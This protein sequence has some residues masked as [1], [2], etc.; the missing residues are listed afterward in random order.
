MAG[1]GFELKRAVHE[2]SY[3]GTLRGYFYAG[4]ISSG[5]WLMSVFSLALIG[6]IS[7]GFLPAQARA[8]TAARD[9]L[10][11]V[12]AF[13]IGYA[14]SFVAALALGRSLGPAGYLAGLAAGQVTLLALLI[15][16]VMA[17]FE[18]GRSFSLTVFG[19]VRRFPALLAI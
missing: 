9:Y 3:I 16:R 6:V 7:V 17:E 14:V 11:I 8:L 1:I 4:V 2:A 13:G 15:A 12:S 5:P 19:Y 10:A 18:L